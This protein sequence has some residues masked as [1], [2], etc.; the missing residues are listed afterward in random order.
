MTESCRVF[1]MIRNADESGGS[2]TGR[3]LDGIV[4]HN[5]KVSA[6]WRT[7]HSSVV[8][9]DSFKDFIS[10]HVDIHPTNLTEIVWFDTI[11][12]K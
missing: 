12:E 8:V 6:C 11:Q 4:W 7:R 9:Y 1:T 3:V 10:I 5:G 2:G